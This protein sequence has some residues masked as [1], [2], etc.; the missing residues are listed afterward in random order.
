MNE[1]VV[2]SRAMIYALKNR[3]VVQWSGC[4]IISQDPISNRDVENTKTTIMSLKYILLSQKRIT[5][6]V[7]TRNLAKSGGGASLYTL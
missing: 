5:P 6:S 4:S 7:I 2:K 1:W 3:E